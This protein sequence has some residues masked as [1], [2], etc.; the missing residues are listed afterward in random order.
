MIREIIDTRLVRNCKLGAFG[1]IEILSLIPA[2]S[3]I[4]LVKISGSQVRAARP[5][6]CTI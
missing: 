1:R 6:G 5:G 4:P 3:A 2:E